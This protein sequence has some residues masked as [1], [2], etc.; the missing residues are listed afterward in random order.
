MSLSLVNLKGSLSSLM[1]AWGPRSEVFLF[2]LPIG[3][4]S[5]SVCKAAGLLN[6]SKC[7]GARWVVNDRIAYKGS[8]RS[9]VNCQTLWGRT[10][11][12]LPKVAKILVSSA[13]TETRFAEVGKH[14]RKFVCPKL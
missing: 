12:S 9:L 10:T 8:T 11:L 7:Q 2:L 4:C 6:L 3:S 5:S 14:V 13:E 1:R